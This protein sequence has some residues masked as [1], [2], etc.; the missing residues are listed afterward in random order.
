MELPVVEMLNEEEIVGLSR[1]HMFCW[2]VFIKVSAFADFHCL[3]KNSSLGYHWGG[4]SCVIIINV[5][6]KKTKKNPTGQ[7]WLSLAL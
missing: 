1:G 4:Q 7:H 5:F 2:E 6:K 3:F